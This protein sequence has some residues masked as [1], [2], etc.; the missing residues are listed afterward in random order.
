MPAV[1]AF[2]MAILASCGNPSLEV[3]VSSLSAADLAEPASAVLQ[4]D[5]VPGSCSMNAARAFVAWRID[6]DAPVPVTVRIGAA[7]GNLFA[8]G[9]GST[10]LAETGA[11][12]TEGL[13]LYLVDADGAVIATAIAPEISC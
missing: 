11:W 8:Q 3:T 9:A 12:V 4:I 6:A 5:L 7:T 1:F 2:A 13:E 10:G